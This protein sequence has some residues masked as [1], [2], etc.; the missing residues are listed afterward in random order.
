MKDG[1]GILC[2]TLG[3]ALMVAGVGI[4]VDTWPRYSVAFSD[5]EKQ[6]L[7]AK[8]TTAIYS[9]VTGAISGLL[10]IV[11]GVIANK[12]GALAKH[13]LPPV[14]EDWYCSE[15]N[16]M[17]KGELD[18]CPDCG[19]TKPIDEPGRDASPNTVGGSGQDSVQEE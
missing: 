10:F 5:L 16:H 6:I 3:L 19:K 11:L 12:V 14:V 15:C 7:L 17:V 9:L 1:L 2:V 4:C 8:K 18:A 13:L